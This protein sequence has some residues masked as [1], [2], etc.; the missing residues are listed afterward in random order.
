[1]PGAN[2]PILLK[3]VAV[4]VHTDIS[5]IAVDEF[6]RKDQNSSVIVWFLVN[7]LLVKI[8]PISRGFWGVS[9]RK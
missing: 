4:E 3:M 9:S 8:A 2:P 6:L 7:S 5:V 1:V